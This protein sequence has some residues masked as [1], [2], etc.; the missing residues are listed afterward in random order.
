MAFVV[1]DT[2]GPPTLD[3]LRAAVKEA[4]VLGLPDSYHGELPHAYVTLVEDATAEAPEIC[5][6]LNGRLGKHERVAEVVVRD[7]LPKT[8]I[9]K[10]SRK[11]LLAEIMAASALKV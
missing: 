4:L 1:P 6:W 2:A 11:D 7:S 3:S 9:G 5:A 8:M 10:L